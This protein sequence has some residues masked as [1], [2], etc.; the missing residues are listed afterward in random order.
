MLQIWKI[1][2]DRERLIGIILLIIIAWVLFFVPTFYY[3]RTYRFEVSEAGRTQLAGE[4]YVKKGDFLVADPKDINHDSA[5]I[6]YPGALIEPEAYTPLV[7]KIASNGVMVVVATM[8]FNLAIF[9]PDTA[10]EIIE[11]Y[12]EIESWVIVGHSLGGSMAAQNSLKNNDIDGLVLLGSYTPS[13]VD[14]SNRDL[15]VVSITGSNDLIV[16][17]EK[18]ESALKKL[19]LD[20]KIVEI[21]GGNH[22][23]FGNYGFQTGDGYADITSEQQQDITVDEIM[24]LINALD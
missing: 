17:R 5:V 19:P 3:S 2:E 14:L 15:K 10:N 7:K 4:V 23:Q 6:I 12:D 9:A 8:P 21:E 24:L 16:D 22:A 11:K 18:Q 13:Y 1:F 20:T